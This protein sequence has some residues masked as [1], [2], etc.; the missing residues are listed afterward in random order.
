MYTG[1]RW[2]MDTAMKFSV[3]WIWFIISWKWGHPE[4]KKAS[5]P[6]DHEEPVW[7]NYIRLTELLRTATA[8]SLNDKNRVL[9]L[10]SDKTIYKIKIK[11]KK[12]NDFVINVIRADRGLRMHNTSSSC[13]TIE[14]YTWNQGTYGCLHL[15]KHWVFKG[16]A[17]LILGPC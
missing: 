11:T 17:V 8:L 15:F 14:N 9:K 5:S 4:D 12:S 2:P 16:A 10:R 3:H 7:I 13:S 6:Y 1:L